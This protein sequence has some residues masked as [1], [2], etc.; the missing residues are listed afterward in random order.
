VNDSDSMVTVLE[1]DDSQEQRAEKDHKRRM[2]SMQADSARSA[3]GQTRSFETMHER[4]VRLAE[5]TEERHRT[6]F[7][8]VEAMAKQ[9][10]QGIGKL[11]DMGAHAALKMAE[12]VG[13]V[14]LLTVT[15]K[16]F[17][18]GLRGGEV[19]LGRHAIA[20]D[21]LVNI[22]RVARLAIAPTLLTGAT[23]GAGI[24]AEYAVMRTAA[25]A[26]QVQS[27]SLIAA[28][29]GRSF[30]NVS[31]IGMAGV[32]SGDGRA[33][34]QSVFGGKSPGQIL[35]LVDQYRDLKDPVDKAAFAVK[36]FGDNA[37]RAMPL[38]RDRLKENIDR[39][40]ELSAVL[41]SKARISLERFAQEMREPVE[42]LKSMASWFR[43]VRE[44]SK[45]W[46]AGVTA[47]V[48]EV[49]HQTQSFQDIRAARSKAL[50]GAAGFP[51]PPETP[52]VPSDL[53]FAAGAAAAARERQA[54]LQARGTRFPI[55]DDI[56]RRSQ[57]AIGRFNDDATLEG[58]HRRKGE[59]E[60]RFEN[61][62]RQLGVT[63]EKGG[64]KGTAL[65]EGMRETV[66]QTS[67]EMYTL[68]GRIK[69]ADRV[70]QQG[71]AGFRKVQA[72][73]EHQWE[74]V[75]Q[76]TSKMIEG[77]IVN[78]RAGQFDPSVPSFA[79]EALQSF[80]YQDFTRNQLPFF[81]TPK[82]YRDVGDE[83]Q[84]FED[85][86]ASELVA[87]E[88]DR[89]ASKREGDERKIAALQRQSRLE[90]QIIAIQGTD[91]RRVIEDTYS[92]RLKRA[93]AVYKIEKQIVGEAEAGYRKEV[94]ADEARIERQGELTRLTRER[95]DLIKRESTS[96]IETL[97]KRPG[98]F[99]GQLLNTVRN[100]AIQPI[101][102]GLGG[103]AAQ[104]LAPFLSRGGASSGLPVMP[105]AGNGI[106][107]NSPGEIIAG[108]GDWGDGNYISAGGSR[109]RGGFLGRLE[110]MF[111]GGGGFGGIFKNFK[112]MNWGGLTRRAYDPFAP[113][114]NGDYTG[115]G[116]GKITGVNGLAGAA[117]MAGGTYL[118]Q[119]GL[120]GGARGTGGGML[121]GT[122]GGAA[123]GFA[124]GGPL[125]AGIG[126]GAGFLI[127]LG[128]KLA[129]VESQA[130]QAHR[131]IMSIYHVDIPEQ[132]GTMQQILQIAAQ[133]GSVSG[134]VRSSQA[135][136]LIE[137]YALALGRTGPGA[138]LSSPRS[139]SLVQQGSTLYQGLN[140][141]NGSGY[142]FQ[143][144]LPTLG[145][146]SGVIPTFDPYGSRGASFLQL[147]GPATTALL[148]GQVSRVATPEYVGAQ[149][150][151]A[152]RSG[153]TRFATMGA[154]IAPSTIFA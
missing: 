133:Y 126:A 23:L 59:A 145:A 81:Q 53:Q 93:E 34:F 70:V 78:S 26:R 84:K 68:T 132:S 19:D 77:A 6:L 149:N 120:L 110:G 113:G 134:A 85:R 117:L 48:H 35:D 148:S 150:V 9:T 90:E 124:L 143:S 20:L 7:S 101:A 42:G 92:L 104:I 141:F 29:S 27:D 122:I 76:A 100:A 56:I 47:D 55:S 66:L 74:M 10:S 69:A 94:A 80:R 11:A 18:D 63:P 60:T 82:R 112:G 116:R 129:G 30:Q 33:Q 44:E 111:P 154:V 54:E 91:A 13:A 8:R 109:G 146:S 62:V 15:G 87:E 14:G 96:L 130:H 102:S 64:V 131:L 125:G 123:I 83:R 39:A 2:E 105:G 58:L 1:F 16:R 128:E 135:R 21:R 151:A 89:I 140:Y 40:S 5:R 144:S 138:F 46:V 142:N 4:L 152:L 139:A 41:D 147:D 37:E 75:K 38:L 118:A 43:S 31:T 3:S 45:L 73:L 52:S 136:Q 98:Q 25:Q 137:M 115:T 107:F 103:V 99:G 17:F 36:N 72:A 88:R 119:A 61:A 108:G 49:V 79:S 121:M 86:Q 67:N 50:R 28:R 24:L 97:F 51:E 65:E 106:L 114:E 153:G 12:L 71:E 22:Y 32:L 95:F 127:G 57:A